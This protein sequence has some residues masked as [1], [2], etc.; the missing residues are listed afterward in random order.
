MNFP[1]RLRLFVFGILIGCLVVWG[2]L[3]RGRKFPAWT[4][5]G[6]IL[7]A[8]QQYPVKISQPARC[9]MQCNNISENDIL[10][11]INTADVIFSESTVRDIEI[12]EYIL[13]G[14]G[15]DG[16]KYKMRFRSRTE[17]NDLM[18]VITFG[19]ALKTCDCR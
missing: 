10:S 11:I 15:I 2:L 19:A 8:L 9:M 3:M 7:E 5:E 17:E 4:P 6:R 1:R 12:P 18:E 16:R 14:Q 13:Q